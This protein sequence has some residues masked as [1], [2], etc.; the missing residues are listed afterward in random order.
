MKN[1]KTNIIILFIKILFLFFF[2]DIL[3]GTFPAIITS[4]ISSSK[5]G[6]SIIAEIVAISIALIVL[7]L[8][9]NK[10]IFNGKRE[11]FFKSLYIGLPMFIISIVYLISSVSQLVISKSFNIYNFLALVLYCLTIGIFEEFL[12][13]GWILNEFLEEHGSN[14]KQVITSIILSALIFGGMHIS[15][16]WIAHQDPFI[17]ILQICNAVTLGVFLGGVYY[18]TKNIWGVIFLH[19]FYDFALMLGDINEIKDCTTNELTSGIMLYEIVSI[20]VMVL[21]FILCSAIIL[22]KSKLNPLLDEPTPLSKTDLSKERTTKALL[23]VGVIL[24]NFIPLPNVTQEEIDKFQT[25][26]D[27]DTIKIDEYNLTVTNRTEFNIDYYNMEEIKAEQQRIEEKTD[28]INEEEVVEEQI[29][30]EQQEEVVEE[31][32]EFWLDTKKEEIDQEI[33]E[34]IE[35][36]GYYNYKIYIENSSVVLENTNTKDKIATRFDN[37][38]NLYVI[39]FKDQTTILIQTYEDG[40]SVL[41]YSRFITKDNVSNAK[42]YLQEIFNTF[43]K[44][45]TPDSN[46]LGHITT[47]DNIYPFIKTTNGEYMLLNEDG[48]LLIIK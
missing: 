17:T 21:M 36:A 20:G 25:C 11:G 27:Y 16:I 26:Y 31:E 43:T 15:N 10:Y 48:E 12:C 47:K 40:N 2:I 24:V 1:K 3:L 6:L 45:I 46:V 42:L 34:Q 30:E 7:V 35:K 29:E 9:G 28:E 33:E 23:I 41:Y 14:R 18:R 8:S 4:I 32:Q 13:R 39:N 19:G 5:Y 44:I 38:L 22:R 37:I